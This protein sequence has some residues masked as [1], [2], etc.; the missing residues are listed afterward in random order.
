MEPSWQR[1]VD[2]SDVEVNAPLL[3]HMIVNTIRSYNK[4]HREEYGELVIACDNRH[5]WRRERVSF[6]QSQQESYQEKSSGLDWSS[7]FDTLNM[8]RDELTEVFP[9]PVIDVDGAEADD[10]IGTLAEYSQTL[11]E[12]GPLF[13]DEIIPEPFLIV[14]GDHDFQQL[15]KWPNVRQ[16]APAQKKWVVIT[17]PAEQ[18]LREHIIIGDKGDGIPNMLSPDDTFVSGIRQ[19][20]IRKKLLAEW[21]LMSPED[22]VTGETAHGY[23]RNSLL[24]DLTKTPQDI[25]EDII[26]TYK[27]Q[28]NKEK[29][30]LLNYFIKNKMMSMVDVIDEF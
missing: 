11:G 19:R 22:F 28:T 13:E 14:S 1:F 5:Y 27:S 29:Q 2:R 7:I 12:P 17:E 15:Q 20:P 18:V 24:V 9:Y 3:R 25:K 30:S 8:V 16:W 23:N 10:V 26:N 4:R 21:K 6:L